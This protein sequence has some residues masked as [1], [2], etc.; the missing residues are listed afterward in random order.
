MRKQ[1]GRIVWGVLFIVAGL[2]FA[3]NAFGMWH[4]T[5]FFN[6]WWTLFLILPAV[7]SIIERG[8]NSGNLILLLI[9]AVFLL[10]SQ[11]ILHTVWVGKLLWP[12]VLVLIGISILLGG[13]NG[14]RRVKRSGSDGEQADIPSYRAFFS[15]SDL[16]W[17]NQ[18]FYGATLTAAFGGITLDLRSAQIRQDVV[19]DATAVFG[20]IDLYLPQGVRAV[21]TG[22][23]IFGGVENKVAPAPESAP[24]VYVN[25]TCIFGG[26]DL[27]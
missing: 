7:V 13:F 19:I 16:S 8:P 21:V 1:T 14:A 2:G 4:F 3:G 27:S 17:P 22:T 6:G 25:T 24:T 9:G 15:G 23:P 10:S 12:V 26:T 11:G 20:G 5:L 18:P